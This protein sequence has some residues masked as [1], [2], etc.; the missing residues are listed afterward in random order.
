MVSA[1][2]LSV[3]DGSMYFQ[4]DSSQS[5][6]YLNGNACYL[7]YVKSSGLL[8]YIVNSIQ[9]FSVNLNGD[10][11]GNTLKCHGVDAQGGT[12]YCGSLRPADVVATGPIT[13]PDFYASGSDQRLRITGNGGA[14]YVFFD[15]AGGNQSYMIWDYNA[16]YFN[17]VSGG[18]NRFG[19]ALNGQATFSNG[20]QV[21]GTFGCGAQGFFSGNLTAAV[22]NGI[23]ANCVVVGYFASGTYYNV[24]QAGMNVNGTTGL[25]VYAGSTINTFWSTSASDRRLKENIKRPSL[26]PLDVVRK[27]PIW[28][29]DYIAPRPKDADLERPEIWPQFREHWPF[30]F[31]ADEVDAAMPN[32]TIKDDDGRPV[33]LHPQ[34]LIATLWAAMQQLT[35]RLESAEA[36]LA[37]FPGVAP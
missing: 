26:D 28:S 20:L 3:G 7:A 23:A 29:C 14:S 8:K 13:C 5:Y 19:I 10:I 25:F 34:H 31:M 4:T 35:D 21:N 32:A 15:T 1:P 18:A 33:A 2:T 27:L 11:T 17:Y 22:N 12:I 6:L 37:A 30:S 16:Q 24:N 9:I 36:K